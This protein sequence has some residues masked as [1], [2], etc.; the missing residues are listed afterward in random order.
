MAQPVTDYETHLLTGSLSQA[1]NQL[2]HPTLQI[3]N[4]LLEV[5]HK[6]T[7]TLA[8]FQ[9]AFLKALTVARFWVFLLDYRQFYVGL[10]FDRLL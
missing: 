7:S 10:G 1:S 9:V 4:R 6:I 5:L 2:P 8:T 3:E